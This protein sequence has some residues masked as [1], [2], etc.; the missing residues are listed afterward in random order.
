MKT[1]KFTVGPTQDGQRLDAAA[2]LAD[3]GL[4]RRKAKSII[5]LGGAYVNRKRI[6]RASHIV[7]I[8]DRIEFQF[9]DKALQP[10]SNQ[11]IELSPEMLVADHPAFVILNKPPGLPSQA[12]RDQAVFHVI[13]LLEKLMLKIGKPKGRWILVHRLDKETSGL[14]IVAKTGKNSHIPNGNVSP[15]NC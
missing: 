11:Q 13:P 9:N 2:Q 1:A 3:I 10:G 8:G 14:L 4:S 6:R 7:K 12:T 5:D 15:Q